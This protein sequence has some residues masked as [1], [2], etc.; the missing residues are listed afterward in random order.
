MS[1]GVQ[2]TNVKLSSQNYLYLA[3]DNYNNYF[4]S[5]VLTSRIAR[6]SLNS[7]PN[8]NRTR[9]FH[10]EH[11]SELKSELFENLLAVIKYD[12][13]ILWKA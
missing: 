3:F 10:W 13:I 8:K 12:I 9:S 1:T 4:C 2:F 7:I 6:A 5:S 11:S